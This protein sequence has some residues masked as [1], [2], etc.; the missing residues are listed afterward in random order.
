MRGL[1]ERIGIHCVVDGQ[2]GST[3]K[4]AL[5]A[6]L[7]EKAMQEGAMFGAC[8]SNAGPN[9][10]HTFYH[11]G[12]K[13][14]LKQLPTFAVYCSLSGFNVP[15]YLSAGAIIDLEIL[16]DEAKRYPDV[17][18][19]IHP[20][21]AVI[22]DWDKYS[23]ADPHGHIAA[24]AGTRSGTGMAQARKINR[25][26]SAVFSAYYNSVELPRNVYMMA[27]EDR[28]YSYY[29]VFMEVSQGFSLGINSEFYPK[30][31]SRE[32]TVMQGISDARIPPHRVARTY[33]SARTFPIRVGNVDGF[34][35]GEF[36]ED[37]TEL[38]WE[39]IGVE[40]ELTTVTKR[41]RRV[42]T[43]SKRQ[44][45]E[46]LDANGADFL[47][48]NFMNYLD[49]PGEGEMME[50]IERIEKSVVKPL[51]GVIY[52]YGPEVTDVREN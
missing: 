13:H 16:I 18:I 42:F 17:D 44:V 39:D 27:Y 26:P 8:V 43:F 28:D 12:N 5:A 14:V 25:D 2:F 38:S 4:G 9:S 3:G 35:S 48:M 20:N 30:V 11:N 45:T 6:W 32:C 51:M 7:A 24:V 15:V 1:F 49:A 22:T 46:A 40:P 52:G 10:G 23:E 29:R 21:A 34:S 19:R 31:T 36:Y 37:Q 33:V 50:A 41:V 47:F